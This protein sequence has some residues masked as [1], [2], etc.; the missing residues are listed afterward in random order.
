MWHGQLVEGSLRLVLSLWG[1]HRDHGSSMRKSIGLPSW[2]LGI[3][4]LQLVP[5]GGIEESELLLSLYRSPLLTGWQLHMSKHS[6]VLR[7]WSRSFYMHISCW[8]NFCFVHE[9]TGQWAVLTKQL[10]RESCPQAASC[11]WPLFRVMRVGRKPCFNPCI[12]YSTEVELGEME[13]PQDQPSC[14]IGKVEDPFKGIIVC[15]YRESLLLQVR[16]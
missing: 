4:H 7:L 1:S 2:L 3:S 13:P 14:R 8:L 9:C 5:R 11:P 6:T 16:A 10:P 15:T 12:V